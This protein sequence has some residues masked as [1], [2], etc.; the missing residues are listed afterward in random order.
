MYFLIHIFQDEFRT[1]ELKIG[2]QV[3]SDDEAYNLCNTYALRNGFS[4]RK[5]HIHRDKSNNIR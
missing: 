1:I 3:H 5:G 2:M 4:I